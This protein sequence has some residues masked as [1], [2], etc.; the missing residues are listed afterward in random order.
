MTKKDIVARSRRLKA[1]LIDGVVF[2]VAII[3][4][5]ILFLNNFEENNSFSILYIAIFPF[6]VTGLQLNLLFNSSQTLGKVH[7]NIIIIDSE[8]GFRAGFGMLLLRVISSSIMRFI[9]PIGLIDAFC[10]FGKE[11]KCLH[12]MIAETVVVD[13]LDVKTRSAIP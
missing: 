7:Q 3:A 6:I 10:I 2:W 8:T 5:I 13:E 12:D 1:Y 9:P 4:G 11:R